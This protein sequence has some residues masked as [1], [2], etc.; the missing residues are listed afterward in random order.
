M[1]DFKFLR[2]RVY[3][4]AKGAKRGVSNPRF[5]TSDIA[6][7]SVIQLWRS[8]REKGAS[9][10]QLNE[11]YLRSVGVGHAKQLMRH[12]LAACRSMQVE[13]SG[14]AVEPASAS[15]ADPLE[16]IQ[17]RERIVMLVQTIAKIAPELQLVIYRRLFDQAPFAR[18]AE[19]SNTTVDVIRGRLERALVLLRTLLRSTCVDDFEPGDAKP[20]SEES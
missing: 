4:A 13:E 2:Q 17:D 16:L 1:T 10:E 6:Q 15:E 18:I 3:S 5:D 19:E 14:D 12:N 7:E 20:L 11:G 8:I 9:D